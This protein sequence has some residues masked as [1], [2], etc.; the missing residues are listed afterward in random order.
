[1]AAASVIGLLYGAVVYPA[2]DLFQSFVPN[3][4][5]NLLIGL[6]I[7]LGSMWIARRGE[8]IGRLLWPGTLLSLLH[9]YTVYVLAMPL[10][11]AFLLH[12]TLLTLSAYTLEDQCTS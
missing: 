4:V 8:L 9:N 1:M 6:P 7:L 5:V 11:L 2:D 3:D 10:N 12:L